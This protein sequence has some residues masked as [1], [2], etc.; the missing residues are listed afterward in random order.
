MAEGIEFD[1]D[2]LKYELEKNKPR[3]SELGITGWLMKRG[4]AKSPQSA[5]GVLVGVL[6][7]VM[8]VIFFLLS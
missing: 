3:E 6:V 4:I 8:V 1:E 5:Q 7:V 2:K